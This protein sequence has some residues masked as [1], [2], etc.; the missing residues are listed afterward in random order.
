M[1]VTYVILTHRCNLSCPHCDLREQ[2]DS[3]NEDKFFDVC[4]TL[5][6]DIVLFGGEPFLFKD[7]LF[8]V[9]T[10]NPKI[11]SISSNM[12]LWDYDIKCFLK[13]YPNVEIASSWNPKRFTKKQYSLWLSNLKDAGI[14]TNINITLTDDLYS[15]DFDAFMNVI[16][17]LDAIP[18]ILTISFEPLVPDYNCESGDVFLSK[19]YEE[20][21]SLRIKMDLNKIFGKK[22]CGGIKTLLPSGNIINDCPQWYVKN[23]IMLKECM[24]CDLIKICKPCKKICHCSFPKKFYNKLKA[25]GVIE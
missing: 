7:R 5:T 9:L 20:M 3:F 17:D 13:H 22:Y 12:L 19:V 24:S 18:S 23:H 11:T 25:E 4:K 14:V 2:S 10:L 1:S 16:K 21:K 8:K 6:G 15:F